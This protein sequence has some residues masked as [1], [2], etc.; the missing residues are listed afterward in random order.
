[1]KWKFFKTNWFPIA[2]ILLV[3]ASIVKKNLFGFVNSGKSRNAVEKI[4]DNTAIAS[5]E[6]AHAGIFSW[7]SRSSIE[8][9]DIPESV[10][11][12]FL[13]RFGKVAAGEQEKFGIPASVILACAYVNS[14]SGKRE[15]AVQ[16]Q[17]YFGLGCGGTWEGA[18]ET[19]GGVCIR[20]YEK[21][22]DSF[23]DF[24]K[25]LSGRK[26][27]DAL[28]QACGK[29]WKAWAKALDNK[30]ISEVSDFEGEMVKVIESYR[31]FELDK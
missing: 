14:F 25:Y 1:M 16:Y 6:E 18:T 7:A 28:R 15:W 5:T 8:L 12:P 27:F 19:V 31:L 3:L 9:P 4:T 20:R 30:K 2:F 17:N 22:W 24:S 13:Q 21:A 23:R 10:A 26:D 11:I 29:D